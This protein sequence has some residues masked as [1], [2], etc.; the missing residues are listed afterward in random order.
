MCIIIWW[1]SCIITISCDLNLRNQGQI[2]NFWDIF[3]PSPNFFY[4]LTWTYKIW[5]KGVLSSDGV[6]CITT[7][8]LWLWSQGHV[9]I[10]FLGGIFVSRLIL[11]IFCLWNLAWRCIA[12]WWCVVYHQ[13]LHVTLTSRSYRGMTVHGHRMICCLSPRPSCELDLYISHV[14]ITCDLD[15][16]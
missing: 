11:F 7:T 16:K 8:Y 1:L 10:I 6:S 14:I 12:T 4:L 9:L 5:Y 13:D 2:I 3:V 15:V